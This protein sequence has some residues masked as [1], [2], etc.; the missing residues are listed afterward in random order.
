[1]P[2]DTGFVSLSFKLDRGQES[3]A[4]D[5][6][7]YDLLMLY[8]LYNDGFVLIVDSVRT[9]HHKIPLTAFTH[10]HFG[11]GVGESVWS[12]PVFKVFG[13]R[14]YFPHKFDRGIQYA[15]DPELTVR[16]VIFSLHVFV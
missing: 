4:A 6:V 15:G 5:V 14:P 2:V 3:R 16:S 1:M 9:M 12:P 11:Y 10:L 8:D 13:I 7:V